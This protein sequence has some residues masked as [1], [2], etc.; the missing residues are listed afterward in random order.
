MNDVL[1]YRLL[2]QHIS[3]QRTSLTII[4]H[5]FNH[6]FPDTK[7]RKILDRKRL[8]MGMPSILETEFVKTAYELLES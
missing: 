2:I 6:H 4:T 1:E 5:R 7:Y 3:I 8:T